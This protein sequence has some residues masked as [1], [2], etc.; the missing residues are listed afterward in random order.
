MGGELLLLFGLILVNGFFS[1]S[2]MAVVSSRKA[3]LRHEAERGR[4]KYRLALETAEN[5]SRF[6]STIQVAITLVGTLTGAIGGATI[7]YQ[8]ELFFDGI[9]FLASAAAPLSIGIVVVVTTFV[10][11]VFGEL[12]PKNL[13]LAK[14]EAVAAAVIRPVRFF[15]V[16]FSPV[17]RL[18]SAVTDL[19]VRLLGVGKHQEPPVTEEEVKVLIAQ[20]AEAGV[21]DDRERE[22]VEGV[23]SLGDLRV[24][25]LMTPRPEVVFV[26]L[27]DGTEA[28]RRGVLE[29]ARYGYLPA[30]E[31]DLD[32]VVGMIPV[33]EY[34]AAALLDEAVDPR[35]CLRKPVMIPESISA[36][37]AFSA[38]KEGEVKTALILDEYG[39]VSGLVALADIM[40]S[41]VGDLPQT[42]DGEEPGV[43]RREDGSWLVDGALPIGRFVEELELSESFLDGEYETVAGLVLD[44]MGS[45]PRAGEKCGW[46]GCLI[47][48]V[49]MDGNRIDKLLVVKTETDDDEKPGEPPEPIWT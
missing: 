5:P 40:E 15:S 48:V 19:V 32:R 12:V 42:G 26:D 49:D 4:K 28:V 25:S 21:F 36:L 13:A 38:I 22:M 33:K 8:L 14:P 34:L 31:G 46:D 20:G 47:E 24:T 45:I 7:A 39:G 23:L 18:L 9:P 2:E 30:V 41:V 27:E 44:R 11:V 1:L 3:R 6:L 43:V 16:L 37:K 10:A 29:N 35:S 17:A